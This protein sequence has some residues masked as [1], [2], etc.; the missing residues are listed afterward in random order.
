MPWEPS[1]VKP[2]GVARW[3]EE[4]LPNRLTVEQDEALDR[5]AEALAEHYNNETH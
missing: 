5:L 3:R 4:R 2:P 1:N